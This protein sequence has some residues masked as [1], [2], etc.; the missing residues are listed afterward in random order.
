MQDFVFQCLWYKLK[1]RTRLKPWLKTPDC[2]PCGAQEIVFHTLHNYAFYASINHFMVICFGDWR[3]QEKTGRWMHFCVSQSLST[4]PGLVLWAVRKAHWAVRCATLPL[5]SP[6]FN[7]LVTK[8]LG[9]L[10]GLLLWDPLKTLT[11]SIQN[12]FNSLM[13]YGQEGTPPAPKHINYKP[14]N[15]VPWHRLPSLEIKEIK[16]R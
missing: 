2:P 8:W 4:V 5:A 16:T 13:H 15:P 1:M 6:G 9:E 12:F 14:T 3:I 7:T 10:R 11:P